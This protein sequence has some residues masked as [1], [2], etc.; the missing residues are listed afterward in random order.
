MIR[1]LLIKPTTR[2]P[3]E[4]P[5]AREPLSCS[6]FPRSREAFDSYEPGGIRQWFTLA[7]SV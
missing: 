6:R 3:A 5:L 7:V 1:L 2:A 4:L